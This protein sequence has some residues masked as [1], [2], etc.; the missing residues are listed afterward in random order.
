MP[1][2]IVTRQSVILLTPATIRT[3]T[4]TTTSLEVPIRQHKFNK[5]SGSTTG[6]RLHIILYYDH[7]QERGPLVGIHL[8]IVSGRCYH[9]TVS[10]KTSSMRIRSVSMPYI[11]HF[12]CQIKLLETGFA[13]VTMIPD[14]VT[15][16]IH[17]LVSSSWNNFKWN[18]KHPVYKHSQAT[19]EHSMTIV[20]R[21]TDSCRLK[22]D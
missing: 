15:D 22:V 13:S 7:G 1:T 4:D 21:D 9:K 14:F 19:C 10:P 3:T 18:C 16:W 11:S 17:T 20:N 6:Y 12:I 8:P 5:L 2:W